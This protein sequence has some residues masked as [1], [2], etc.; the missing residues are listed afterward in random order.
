METG[1]NEEKTAGGDN[2]A[3]IESDG[4]APDPADAV[5]F[6]PIQTD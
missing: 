3:V 4:K 6:I 1:M 5:P 2:E